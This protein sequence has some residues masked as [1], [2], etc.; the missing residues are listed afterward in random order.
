AQAQAAAANQYC[1]GIRYDPAPILGAANFDVTYYNSGEV[2][3]SGIDGQ[4]DWAFDL[5]PGMVT[6]NVLV[7]YYLHYKSTELA[8]NPMV[9]YVGTL[10]TSQNGLNPGA[11]EYRVL[12]TLGYGIG[13]SR[14]SLQW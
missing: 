3:I 2:A 8:A 5:G 13:P 6:T 9:D 11:F 14:I 4:L 7:N 1:A 12:A 10:G